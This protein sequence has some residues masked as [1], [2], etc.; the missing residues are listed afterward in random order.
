MLEKKMT[1]KSGKSKNDTFKIFKPAVMTR[2]KESEQNSFA[3]ET[4][5]MMKKPTFA[6]KRKKK[7]NRNI[8]LDK[9]KESTDS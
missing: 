1:A 6:G 5:F 3:A 7:S 4:P 8:K 2:E 9:T